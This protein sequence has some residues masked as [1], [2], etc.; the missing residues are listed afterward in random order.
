MAKE[1]S[2]SQQAVQSWEAG[3]G[4]RYPYCPL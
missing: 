4:Y 3:G 2:V 1:L